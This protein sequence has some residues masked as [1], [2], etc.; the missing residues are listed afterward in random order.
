MARCYVAEH[1]LREVVDSALSELEIQLTGGI[2]WNTSLGDIA[3]G[4]T[5]NVANFD[6]TPDIGLHVT[7][8][9][10]LRM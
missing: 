6:N 8:S 1:P 2:R 9:S 7:W 10:T 5:E 4:V 3:F